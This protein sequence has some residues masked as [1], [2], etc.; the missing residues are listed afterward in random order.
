MCKYDLQMHESL[1]N[2]TGNEIKVPLRFIAVF[3][4]AQPQK[5]F[6]MAFNSKQNLRTCNMQSRMQHAEHDVACGGAQLCTAQAG[7]Q[8]SLRKVVQDPS[9][10]YVG[11]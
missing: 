3:C 9:D 8:V 11:L 6:C 2:K 1:Y 4:L 5:R 10:A 7:S